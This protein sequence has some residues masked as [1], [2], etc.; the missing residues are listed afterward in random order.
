MAA[1]AYESMFDNLPTWIDA[2]AENFRL[3]LAASD[4]PPAYR[5]A[6]TRRECS[7]PP[8]NYDGISLGDK[9]V[10]LNQLVRHLLSTKNTY[11]RE[12]FDGSAFRREYV[13]STL[14]SLTHSIVRQCVIYDHRK[15]DEAHALDEYDELEFVDPKQ[16]R[17]FAKKLQLCVSREPCPKGDGCKKQ[18]TATCLYFHP[19]VMREYFLCVWVAILE[20]TDIKEIYIRLKA[21]QG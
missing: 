1:P 19:K 10:K 13:G 11:A 2:V 3:S 6:E 12:Y 17:R 9:S 16:S 15:F 8:P 5:F 14:A 18:A 7:L 21:S 20:D 4:P